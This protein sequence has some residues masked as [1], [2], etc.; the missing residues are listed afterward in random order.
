LVAD[1]A[2]RSSADCRDAGRLPANAATKAGFRKKLSQ[3]D[4]GQANGS[5][6]PRLFTC[7]VT[8]AGLG[9]S[10]KSTKCPYLVV[11]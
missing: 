11:F 8:S 5:T 9:R 2:C 3:A 1:W 7:G 10:G 6:R 4:G